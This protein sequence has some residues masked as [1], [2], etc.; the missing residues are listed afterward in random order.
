MLNNLNAL[1]LSL[2]AN[3]IL[4]LLSILPVAIARYYPSITFRRI[5]EPRAFFYYLP[6]WAKRAKWAH[7]NTFEAF[8]IHSPAVILNI[9]HLDKFPVSLDLII[10]FSLLHPF[11]RILYI[12]SY[13]FDRALLRLFFWGGSMICSGVLYSLALTAL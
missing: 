8:I 11:L 3:A 6:R 1:T 12:F 2:I 9:I 7:D 13:I 4:T 10:V 5:K